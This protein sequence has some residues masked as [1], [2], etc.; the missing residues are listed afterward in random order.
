MTRAGNL[1]LSSAGAQVSL[2]TSSD[3]RHPAEHIIDGNPETFWT[4]TGMFPQEFI[5]SMNGLQKIG[6]IIME[7]SLIK[8]VKIYSSA[9]KEPINFELCLEREL[10]HVEGQFLTEEI[11][12]PGVQAT[13]LRFLIVSGYDHFVSMRSVSAESVI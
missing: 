3:E 7:S 2:A 9:S 6:K 13:H 8:N 11:T 10:E 1:C 5:I 4:T 12:L